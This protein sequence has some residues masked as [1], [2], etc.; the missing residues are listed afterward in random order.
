M[1][2]ENSPN[3]TYVDNDNINKFINKNK[4]KNLKISSN[5]LPKQKMVIIDVNNIAK[6]NVLTK[7]I[8]KSYQKNDSV[9]P[10]TKSGLTLN[11]NCKDIGS[12]RFCTNSEELSDWLNNVIIKSNAFPSF[13]GDDKYHGVASYFRFMK[14]KNGGM[15]YPHYDSDYLYMRPNDNLYTA[16][17]LVMYLSDCE[18]GEI[19]FI[20]DETKH[21]KDRSD[22]ERQATDEEIFLR[23]K[24]RVGRIV[25]FPH[26]LCHS[27]MEF[28]EKERV[29]IR[30]D[31]VFTRGKNAK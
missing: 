17:S 14:Y 25:L 22:W 3:V 4:I 10:V 5:I 21:A 27:V 6:E 28:N 12:Q 19:V 30:G 7:K 11:A 24:S 8:F 16:Y 15:H 20:N 13:H 29:I 23:I 18:T 26:E 2:M 31:V 9:Y 1:I